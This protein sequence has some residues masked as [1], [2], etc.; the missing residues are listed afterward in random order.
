[1]NFDQ[2]L[3]DYLDA[4]DAWKKAWWSVYK[5]TLKAAQAQD[6]WQLD[7]ALKE[8]EQEANKAMHGIPK[9]TY[10]QR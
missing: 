5:E 6:G 1:M 8:A 3:L 7:R 9:P 4:S 2:K 10:P